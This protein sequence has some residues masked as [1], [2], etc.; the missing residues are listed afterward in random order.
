MQT[1]KLFETNEAFGQM[2]LVIQQNVSMVED[3]T[4]AAQ[5]LSRE[6]ERLAALVGSFRTDARAA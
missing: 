4:G 2:D 3:V 6:T 1:E 5:R